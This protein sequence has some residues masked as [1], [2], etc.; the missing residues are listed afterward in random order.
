MFNNGLLFDFTSLSLLA[1]LLNF[2]K[3]INPVNIKKISKKGKLLILVG[4]VTT[5]VSIFVNSKS[6]LVLSELM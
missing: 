3:S 1:I 6:L 4:L 5:I 2:T